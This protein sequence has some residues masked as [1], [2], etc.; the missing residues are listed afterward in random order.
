[1]QTAVQRRKGSPILTHPEKCTGCL[2]CEFRCSLRFAKAFTPCRSAI[3]IRRLGECAHA[4]AMAFTDLCDNCGICVR[5]CPYGA[6]EST[7]Q[8]AS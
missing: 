8:Q 4:F 6:L 1:M 2:T 3:Q 5:F 7:G